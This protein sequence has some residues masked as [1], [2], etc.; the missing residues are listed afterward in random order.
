MHV[1]TDA[2]GAPAAGRRTVSQFR[3]QVA[4]KAAIGNVL[5]V[6]ISLRTATGFF[7][8]RPKQS[9]MDFL[10]TRRSPKWPPMT[11]RP[12]VLP[13]PPRPSEVDS[14]AIGRCPSRSTSLFNPIRDTAGEAAFFWHFGWPSI[15]EYGSPD[16]M[17][18]LRLIESFC[19]PATAGRPRLCGAVFSSAD[20]DRRQRPIWSPLGGAKHFRCSNALDRPCTCL[21][22]HRRDRVHTRRNKPNSSVMKSPI[23]DSAKPFRGFC[24]CLPGI[25]LPPV[26]LHAAGIVHEAAQAATRWE[27]GCAPFCD[28]RIAFD[29]HRQRRS[30]FSTTDERR[31]TSAIGRN[32]EGLAKTETVDRRR[33]NRRRNAAAHCDGAAEA[34]HDVD[35]SHDGRDERRSSVCVAAHASLKHRAAGRSRVAY[36][37]AMFFFSHPTY[38]NG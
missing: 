2:A 36:A 34:A 21:P 35:Q 28:R 12:L 8:V 30:R 3:R 37:P 31:E 5:G 7:R 13:V 26:P 18:P 4:R 6:G 38:V 22:F 10:P 17:S 32:N 24:G 1:T 27:R 16:S 11:L 23:R 19:I 14:R 9:A 15:R 33:R 20:L 25:F 29:R